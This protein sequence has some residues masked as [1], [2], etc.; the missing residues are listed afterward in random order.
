M[1]GKKPHIT[2]KNNTSRGRL[3]PDLSFRE[4]QV[5]QQLKCQTK[6]HLPGLPHHPNFPIWATERDGE[7]DDGHINNS[8]NGKAAI[9][10]VETTKNPEND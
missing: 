8:A 9:S 5:S 6:S 10:F 3:G 4:H 1:P 7:D 2:S